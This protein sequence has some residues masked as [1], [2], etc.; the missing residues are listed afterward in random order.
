MADTV[1]V[2]VTVGEPGAPAVN[3]M[4]SRTVVT[5]SGDM[6]G[7]AIEALRLVNDLCAEVRE[8]ALRQTK[9]VM[10]NVIGQQ[11]RAARSG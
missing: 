3:V 1:T 5:S 4:A 2:V 9:V 8:E 6:E 7:V 11:A 10:E